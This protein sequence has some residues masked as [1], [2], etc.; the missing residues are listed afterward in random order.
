VHWRRLQRAMDLYLLAPLIARGAQQEAIKREVFPGSARER[1]Y[2]YLV[3][4]GWASHMKADKAWHAVED[5]QLT[6]KQLRLRTWVKAVLAAG[7]Q[8]TQGANNASK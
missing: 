3:V 2:V 8:E 1:M 4:N 6:T 5:W 7:K